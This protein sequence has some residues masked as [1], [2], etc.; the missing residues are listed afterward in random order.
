MD[1]FYKQRLARYQKK[2]FRYMKYVFNDH[3]SLFLVFILGGGVF[4]YTELIKQIKGDFWTW[5]ILI[6][7][8]WLGSL[9]VGRLA[10]LV[11]EADKVFLLPKE[12]A[13][14][15]YLKKAFT[16]SLILPIGFLILV[17]GLVLPLLIV[18]ND[19]GLIDGLFFFVMLA[20]LKLCE[21][22]IQYTKLYQVSKEKVTKDKQLFMAISSLAIIISLFSYSW[23]GSL[24]AF[25]YFVFFQKKNSFK[26]KAL[27]NWD[28]AIETEKKRQKKIYQFINL[29]TDVPGITSSVKRRKYLD[30][31]LNKIKK[32]QE[33][34]YLYLYARRFLR[35]AEYSGLYVRLLVIASVIMLFTKELVFVLPVASVVLFLICFQLLPLYNQFDYMVMTHLY[36]INEKAKQKSLQR[37]FFIL[38]GI[39]T[40]VM[41]IV[42]VIAL[43]DVKNIGITVILLLF[44]YGALVGM[45]VPSR[46][47]KMKSYS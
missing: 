6:A 10:L 15:R 5:Q 11:E 27:F 32:K 8:I 2:L 45:Y 29:F 24:I 46:I 12:E 3:M 14:P 18:T 30:V 9:F 22:N 43:K 36:P 7:L 41:L 33:N 16:H 23:M 13:L 4:Y 19:S 38:M 35:E 44:L 39:G 26:V 25:V 37:L 17:V 1:V 34:T 42:S 47:K 28:D 40:F 31:F 21:M 20:L